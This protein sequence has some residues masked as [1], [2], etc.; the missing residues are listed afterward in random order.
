MSFNYI[1]YTF[2]PTWYE[3]KKNN[4]GHTTTILQTGGCTELK[5]LSV[6]LSVNGDAGFQW[7]FMRINQT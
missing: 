4:I 6:C 1:I 2:F 5:L 7:S 3:I